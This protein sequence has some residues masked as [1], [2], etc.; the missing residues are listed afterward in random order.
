[1]WLYIASSSLFCPLT[2]LLFPSLSSPLQFHFAVL[3]TTGGRQNAFL[4]MLRRPHMVK[5]I[6]QCTSPILM[7]L[8]DYI[9]HSI[10]ITIKPTAPTVSGVEGMLPSQRRHGWGCC[11]LLLPTGGGESLVS[12]VVVDLIPL[13]ST[14]LEFMNK[15][16]RTNI[17][18]GQIPSQETTSILRLTH[19][20]MQ[21]SV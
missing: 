17:G 15:L 2:K 16:R 11:R 1:M 18:V 4:H 8:L 14:N 10:P 21:E 13:Q 6:L 5:V 19:V 7:N 9:L 12:S 3:S 20:H